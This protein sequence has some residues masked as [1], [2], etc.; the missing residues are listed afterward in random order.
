[1]NIKT[2]EKSIETP[3]ESQ[4]LSEEK[5]AEVTEHSSLTRHILDNLYILLGAVIAGLFSPQALGENI[6]KSKK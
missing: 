1:M 3:V 4:T 2:K 6:F 5:T